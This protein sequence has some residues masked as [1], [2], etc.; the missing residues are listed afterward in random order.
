MI[1]Y[2]C[3]NDHIYTNTSICSKCG[4]RTRIE[5]ADI[6]WCDECNIPIYEEK[7]GCCVMREEG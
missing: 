6:Y 2:Y 5:G 1:R 3:D 4:Q 7:C